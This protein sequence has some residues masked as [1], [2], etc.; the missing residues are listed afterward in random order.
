M[1]AK[2]GKRNQKKYSAK[3][4]K[5]T[6][7]VKKLIKS[8]VLKNSETKHRD[9]YSYFPTYA[10]GTFRS[11]NLTYSIPRGDDNFSRDGDQIDITGYMVKAYIQHAINLEQ[12]FVHFALIEHDVEVTGQ[13]AAVGSPGNYLRNFSTSDSAVWSL[14]QARCKKV[15]WYKRVKMVANYP[16]TQ[17]K[18]LVFS[19]FTRLR[20]RFKYNVASGFGQNTNLYLVNWVT[21]SGPNGADVVAIKLDTRLYFKDL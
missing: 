8:V 1:G 5:D 20:K 12:V 16:G 9:E 10:N 6:Q 3:K 11:S 17:E 4:K 13:Q 21:H 14:D 19:K 15:H 18:A 7:K 2:L